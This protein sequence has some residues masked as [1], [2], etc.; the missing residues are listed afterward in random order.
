MTERA[1]V[2]SMKVLY[3]H[4]MGLMPVL[5][6]MRADSTFQIC[7]RDQYGRRLRLSTDFMELSLGPKAGN[8]EA[9][10]YLTEVKDQLQKISILD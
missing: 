2:S 4:E 7:V 10:K 6:P 3:R 9:I 8:A 5:T 1:P